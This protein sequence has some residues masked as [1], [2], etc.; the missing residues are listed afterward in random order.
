MD[1]EARVSV[2]ESLDMLEY[3]NTVVWLELI[4]SS[5]TCQTLLKSKF[6]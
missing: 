1:S 4:F 6:E 3:V 5:V 2:S